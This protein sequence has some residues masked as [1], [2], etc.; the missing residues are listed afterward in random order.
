MENTPQGIQ[1]LVSIYDVLA[2]RQSALSRYVTAATQSGQMSYNQAVAAFNVQYPPA[3]WASRVDPEPVPAST[4]QMRPGFVYSS[5]GH[6]ALWTGREW[7]P[8]PKG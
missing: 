1:K 4:A 3:Q 8:A 5:N 6:S 7:A 2:D